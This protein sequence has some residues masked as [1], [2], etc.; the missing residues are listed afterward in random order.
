MAAV[1]CVPLAYQAPTF[2][3][4]QRSKSGQI[5]FQWK[6][7]KAIHEAISSWRG[8]RFYE[9]ASI[10][11]FLDDVIKQEGEEKEKERREK[12]NKACFGPKFGA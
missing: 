2:L 10:R 8:L 6:S 11:P 7:R 5:V 9:S 1:A 4:A 12:S 3:T